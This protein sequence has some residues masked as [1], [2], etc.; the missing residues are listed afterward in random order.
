M[1]GESGGG[2]EGE[3]EE[4]EAGDEEEQSSEVEEPAVEEKVVVPKPKVEEKQP[5]ESQQVSPK[6]LDNLTLNFTTNLNN[7]FKSV[8]DNFS[9]KISVLETKLSNKSIDFDNMNISS[10][11]ILVKNGLIEIES[12]YTKNNLI[13]TDY[14]SISIFN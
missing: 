11:Q 5:K 6:E 10:L 12:N 1:A 8:S 14:S 4:E 13:I 2:G 9:S 3:G 7:Y